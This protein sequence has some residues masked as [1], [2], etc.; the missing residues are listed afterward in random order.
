[1]LKGVVGNILLVLAA[2]VA[3]M[4]ILFEVKNRFVA[5]VQFFNHLFER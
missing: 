5:L 2:I 4:M 1:M 3:M